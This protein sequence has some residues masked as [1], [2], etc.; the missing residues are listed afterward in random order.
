MG[1]TIDKLEINGIEFFT[2]KDFM[3][4]YE[5]RSNATVYKMVRDGRAVQRK[6]LG[7]SVFCL[8]KKNN[9]NL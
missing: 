3:T 2:I 7:R 1:K 5:I 6:F 9:Y 4:K 8:D